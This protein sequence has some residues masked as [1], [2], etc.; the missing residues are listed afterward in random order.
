[1]LRE[2]PEVQKS[3]Y[4]TV[5]IAGR[6]GVALETIIEGVYAGDPN[7]GP[8]YAEDSVRVA[9]FKLNKKLAPMG[10]AIRASLGR[11]ARYFLQRSAAE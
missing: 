11:G 5:S 1:M 9:K 3:I 10:L 7:G 4:D 6:A 8:L 2:L